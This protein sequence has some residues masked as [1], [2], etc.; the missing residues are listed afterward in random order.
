MK[1]Q[2]NNL[3][4]SPKNRVMKRMLSIEKIK[5]SEKADAISKLKIFIIPPYICLY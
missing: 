3:N 5:L 1:D 4:A 2:F